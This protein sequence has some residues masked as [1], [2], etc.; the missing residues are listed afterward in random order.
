MIEQVPV[1]GAERG[2]VRTTES[3]AEGRLV[4]RLPR[5]A[6]SNGQKRGPVE[7]DLDKPNVDMQ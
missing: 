3:G 6:A 5:E 7:P 2:I 1:G 4:I